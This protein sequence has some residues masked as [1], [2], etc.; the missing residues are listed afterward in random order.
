MITLNVRPIV[1]ALSRNR[2]GAILVALEIAIALAVMVNAAWIVAQRIQQ[3]EAP[4]GLDERNTFAIGFSGLSSQSDLGAAERTDVAYLR[5]LPGVIAATGTSSVPLARYGQGT[6]VSPDP[7][8]QAAAIRTRAMQIDE[9]TVGTLGVRILSGRNFTAADVLP[10]SNNLFPTY[11][12]VIVTKSLADKLFPDGNALGKAIY[13]DDN[14]PMTIIG[15]TSNFVPSVVG[16]PSYDALLWPQAVG[17][18]G[19]YF[20][21]VRT[22]P[23]KA[24]AILQA[25]QRHLAV[26][27]PDRVVLLAHTLGY[28]R[29]LLDAENRAVALFL[30]VVT[31]LILCVTCL[32]IFGLTTFNVSTRTKQ[33]GT[34]R[35]V[36]AR[37]RD[38]VAHFLVENALILI[39]GAIVGCTLA[40]AVGHWLSDQY[41]LPRLDLHFLA[42][43]LA[44]LALIGQLAA[45]QPARRAASV[46]PSVATRTV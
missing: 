35:A 38:V 31:T 3:I 41:Q 4:S 25:A 46:P 12:Q 9:A 10:I 29:Q 34:M 26:S 33:I 27:N 30:T 45:W 23:G 20:C 14:T 6:S 15:I 1:S 32:G 42:I 8:P 37:K 21:L 43:G 24:E 19:V 2:T 18:Y 11:P 22:E 7:G 16:S 5:S 44:A 17:R 40:L 36:G 13:N 39:M 28:Y